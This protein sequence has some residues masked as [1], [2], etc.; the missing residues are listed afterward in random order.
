MATR[1]TNGYQQAGADVAG[2]ASRVATG[3]LII[4]AA[5]CL[6]KGVPHRVRGVTPTP[7]ATNPAGMTAAA[8]EVDIT[9]P[10]GLP[11][12]GHA[13]NGKVAKGYWL[14]LRGRI[15]AIDDGRGQRL[16][17][18]QL[19][20]GASSALLHRRLARRLAPLGVGPSN[21][22][23]ATSH[24]HGGPGSFFGH[25][26]YNGF[27]GAE[28]AYE[29]RLVDWLVDQIGT[30]IEKAFS[31]LAPA[32]LHIREAQVAAGASFNRSRP[33]WE[34]NFEADGH[35]L[36]TDEVD[37]RLT[38]VR[39]DARRAGR[40]QPI[41]AW[42]IFGVHGTAMPS[43][44]DL[45]HGDVHGLAARKIRDRIEK[46]CGTHGFVAAVA[47]GA[48][49]DVAPGA[50]EGAL[51]E[52]GKGLALRVASHI[53][54][55]AVAAFGPCP[56]SDAALTGQDLPIR[57]GYRE[58]SL[59]SAG[60]SEGRLCP[61]PSLGSP[62]LGGSEE[63]RGPLYGF[64]GMREGT[65]RSPRGCAA[66]KVKF[67]GGAQALFV[68]PEDY[69]DLA[70][71]QVIA[72]GDALVLA[73]IPGEPTTEVGRAVVG[74]IVDPKTCPRTPDASPARFARAAVMGLTNGYATYFTMGPE[75]LAQ[76]YEGGATLY[77]PHQGQLAV[78]ELCGLAHHLDHPSSIDHRPH[79]L[80]FPGEASH[81]F[82]NEPCDTT[83]W[84]ALD[85]DGEHDRFQWRASDPQQLCPLPAIEV[86]CGDD[87]VA[88]DR[89]W[90]LEVR[91]NGE[92]WEA[93]WARGDT[94]TGR[95]C[96]M[97]IARGPGDWITSQ[98]MAG[99]TP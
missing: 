8:V 59:R 43:S 86:R 47:N 29:P 50:D 71:F 61:E 57:V 7:V 74:A 66:T 17:M 88:T 9:P 51:S 98:N 46:K 45:Y 39:I 95:T 73:A 63:G 65:T 48:E 83:T 60:T 91:R 16:A 49:G 31:E 56:A 4:A 12:Y 13:S 44:F 52:Q 18:V 19:D 80:F 41:A 77:G 21:L 32:R 15:I 58:V 3:A 79:R 67:A 85:T 11:L 89:G 76:H 37:R 6:G 90:A 94:H 72:F 40:I 27:V 24:T 87:V 55:A 81:A 62:Q 34:K 97:R 53:A 23:M 99:A 33:A 96:T 30:G 78:E 82:P 64:L 26:F 10:P 75:Y 42:S 38:M 84:E 70:P 36:P 35:A 20:L 93:T 5:G 92:C 69:P 25:R 14:R 2:L 54:D 22:V 28:P 68:K 1:S